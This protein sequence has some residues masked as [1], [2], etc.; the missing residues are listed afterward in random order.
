MVVAYTSLNFE[1]D[2]KRLFFISAPHPVLTKVT[3]IT[4][5]KIMFPKSQLGK[6]S[7]LMKDLFETALHLRPGTLLAC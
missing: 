5:R 3:R 6:L 1:L 7:L 2:L 4:S